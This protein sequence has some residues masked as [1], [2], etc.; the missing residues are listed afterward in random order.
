VK[1]LFLSWA[2]KHYS[3]HATA[4]TSVILS[5]SVSH[6]LQSFEEGR[7]CHL[8]ERHHLGAVIVAIWTRHHSHDAFRGA[9]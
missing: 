9:V 4:I 6:Q 2:S 3:F 1:H 8:A 5:I 7:R